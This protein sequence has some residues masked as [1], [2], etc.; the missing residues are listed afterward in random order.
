MLLRRFRAPIV[1]TT[2]LLIPGFAAC[3][4]SDNREHATPP[5]SVSTRSPATADPSPAAPLPT[6]PGLDYSRPADVAARFVEAS[7]TYTWEDVHEGRMRAQVAPFVTD[8]L[9]RDTPPNPVDYG[10]VTFE[11]KAWVSAHGTRR[12]VV[13]ATRTRNDLPSTEETTVVQVD[14]SMT[15][16][17]D[18]RRKEVEPVSR[19][20][21]LRHTPQTGWRVSASR[22]AP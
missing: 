2:L 9:A 12:T 8:A 3:S 7:L 11:F 13:S 19:L 20:I 5:S 1:L 17:Q 14:G 16:T 10:N 6:A 4:G 22:T 18:G 15:V 21:H